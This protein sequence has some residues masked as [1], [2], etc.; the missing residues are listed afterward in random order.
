[1]YDICSSI[2]LKRKQNKNEVYMQM[3]G[4]SYK[5]LILS[6]E[7]FCHKSKLGEP[8]FCLGI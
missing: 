8:S 3:I 5:L 6:S 1:M 2:K 7:L 4:A